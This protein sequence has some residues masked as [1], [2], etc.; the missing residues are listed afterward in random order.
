MSRRWSGE[1][2]RPA[3]VRQPAV[4]VLIPSYGRAAELAVTL[5]GLAGQDGPDFSVIVSDQSSEPVWDEP[6]VAAMVR[7]LRAQGRAVNLE[8]NLPRRGVAQQRH[9]LLQHSSAP[10]VLF[11]D[12]DVWLE[13][14][15][16]A[17]M[18]TALEEAGCGFVGAAVQGLSYL[19]DY[20]EQ[21]LATLELWEGGVRPE[22]VRSGDPAF[23]RWPLHNAA[24]A[25]HAAAALNLAPN[26]WRLYK[27]AWVG[28][29]V[30]FDRQALVD[31]GG[32]NFWDQ[33]PAN[34]A[35]ED[36]A[37]QWRVMERYGGAGIL[38]SG[39]VHLES[40]TTVPDRSTDAADVVLG[41][42]E[43]QL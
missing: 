24:N 40:P 22:R 35:G 39:A 34:H 11:L 4:D 43:T 6:A 19:D 13:P 41:V 27:V 36:V 42:H 7:V 8:R 10:Q 33:L 2:G 15:M 16:I 31:C 29:C 30:L 21:E 12:N 1:W 26:D 28:G 23:E 38:P 20:R 17:R 37:A 3:P 14:G 5:A 32:F 18:H 9:F 25:A